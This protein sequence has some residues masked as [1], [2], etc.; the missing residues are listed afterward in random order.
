MIT[1]YNTDVEHDGVVYHVQTEDKGLDSPLLLSLV[2]SG[3]AILASKRSSYQDL[4]A[5]GFDEVVLAE[6]LQR[7]HRLICAA[8]N[9]GRIEDL[10]KMNAQSR[11]GPLT[12]PAA[13]TPPAETPHEASRPD[14]VYSETSFETFS[15]PAEAESSSFQGNPEPTYQP[16]PL[17]FEGIP[18]P[19]YQPPPP[20]EFEGIP[21][22]TYQPQ[23]PSAVT[24]PEPSYQPQ[25]PSVESIPQAEPQLPVA[26]SFDSTQEIPRRPS[27]PSAYTVYDSRRHSPQAEAP[28][29]EEGLR[30]FLAGEKDFRGGDAIEMEVCVSQVS[31]SGEAPVSAAVS[32][33]VLGTAFRPVI[34]S[35]KTNRH[36]V[37]SVSTRIPKFSSGRAAIVIKATTAGATIETRRVIH[38]G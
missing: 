19:T 24:K 11:T 38:P 17:E 20:L 26:G 13:L 14:P 23:A 12:M 25:P 18:E 4:I 36:G 7:Q 27:R 30:I 33:K 6:R 21:E 10:K 34:L 5:A 9:A 35:L 31:S 29:V 8:I 28:R 15:K 1:G 37:A 2:Y 3:G 32:V 16:P 22:P